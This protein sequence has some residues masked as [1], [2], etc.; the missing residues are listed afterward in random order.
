[1][2]TEIKK[3]LYDIKEAIDSISQYLADGKDFNAYLK[4]KMLRRAVERVLEIIG[5]ALN[6]LDK[7][8]NSFHISSKK[9]IIGVRNRVIHGY[10]K[11]DNAII[12][13]IIIRYLPVLEQEVERLLCCNKESS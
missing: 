12:W 2:K 13:G 11:I 10:D 4:D 9:Q 7:I 1:M 5:E 8:D 3:Y 6:R